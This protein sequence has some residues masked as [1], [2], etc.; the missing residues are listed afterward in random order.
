M[1]ERG[2]GEGGFKLGA[3]NKIRVG[4]WFNLK[5]C[6]I[7]YYYHFLCFFF[8]FRFVVFYVHYY[9]NFHL[10]IATTKFPI[11]IF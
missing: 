7:T 10:Y 1:H 11:I 5:N 9:Y 6:G 2:G 3:R 8:I 4:G